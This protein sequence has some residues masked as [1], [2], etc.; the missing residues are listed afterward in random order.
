[1]T[2]IE[3]IR[4]R[5]ILDSRGH[6]TLEVD[7]CLKSGSMG[8]FCVPSG[9]STGE[10]E[11]LELRDGDPKRFFGKGVLKAVGHV[12]QALSETLLG[13]NALEQENI[14]DRMIRLDGTPNKS[15]LGANAI[16]GVSLGVAKAAAASQKKSLYRYL[17][18]GNSFS[19]PVPLMNVINGGA[20]ADN[21]LD[22][23]EF[24]IVPYGAS[25]FSEALRCGSEIFH[26]LKSVLHENHWSTAVGDEGGFAP[27]LQS[28]EQTLDI[29]MEAIEQVGFNPGEYVG[30]ALDAASS[31]FYSRE[32]QQYRLRG[33]GE[34]SS[35]ELVS[36]WEELCKNY[37]IVSLED[38]LDQND[39]EGWKILTDRLGKEI[40][41]VGDDLFV[42]NP[43]ILEK[44]IKANIAN[45]LLVKPNQIGTWSET[46]KAIQM[47]KAAGY[48]TVLSH[49]SGE[50]EDTTI[51]DLAVATGSEQI[52]TGSLSR[53]ERIAKYNQLLRIEEELG[54]KAHYFGKKAF[55]LRF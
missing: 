36:Y 27:D 29:L 10:R 16:L 38:G 20:H 23:Q 14:D 9:A 51:A 31:E 54:E 26:S 30:I 39:W 32:T 12:N 48:T 47:A 4:A 35:L 13:Q 52:K 44:G 53:S 41:L 28:N 25:C 15:N 46:L 45:S 19:L 21:G 55:P 5:E 37:P 2:V 34:L 49:R 33:Q 11:A 40:Q 22:V 1:M 42:T 50:T 8:R 43:S 18:T 17:S 6:P 24:M 3:S 7:V